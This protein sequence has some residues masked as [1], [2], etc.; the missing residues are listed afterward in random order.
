MDSN[1]IDDIKNKVVRD[2]KRVRDNRIEI[3]YDDNEK[4]TISTMADCCGYAYFAQTDNLHLLV[5]SCIQSFNVGELTYQDPDGNPIGVDRTPITIVNNK[6][7]VVQ[8]HMM[9]E[10]NGYYPAFLS[11]R[12]E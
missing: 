7:V 2:A 8:F 3:E 6:G 9:C 10:H 11:I 1:Q 4:L 5:D 12:L